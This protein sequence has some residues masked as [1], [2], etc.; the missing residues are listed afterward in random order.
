M[1]SERLRDER[2]RA[3]RHSMNVRAELRFAGEYRRARI[4]DL[5][6]SGALLILDSPPTP[7]TKVELSL[8]NGDMAKLVVV[9]AG[10][11][12]CGVTVVDQSEMGTLQKWLEAKVGDRSLTR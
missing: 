4:A 11:S 2:R 12:F 10:V 6:E 7:G 9:R 1:Y 5:S 3:E 8:E